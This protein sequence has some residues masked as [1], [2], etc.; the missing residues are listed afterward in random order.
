MKQIGQEL[1]T[2]F[3]QNFKEMQTSFTRNATKGI[4]NIDVNTKY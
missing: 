4:L 2:K 1:N 3:I